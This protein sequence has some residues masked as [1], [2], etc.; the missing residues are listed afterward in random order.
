MTEA[1]RRGAAKGMEEV[2]RRRY[3]QFSWQV[4]TEAVRRPRRTRL[5]LPARA[6]GGKHG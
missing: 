5:S 1:L 4:G 6:D 2:L 3:P